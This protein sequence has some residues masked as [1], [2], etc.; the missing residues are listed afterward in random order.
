MCAAFIMEFVA[1]KNVTF[2]VILWKAE[3]YLN[4]LQPMGRKLFEVRFDNFVP[5]QINSNLCVLFK[6]ILGWK[7]TQIVALKM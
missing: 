7:E 5:L 1:L 6:F 2:I 3:K 4:A